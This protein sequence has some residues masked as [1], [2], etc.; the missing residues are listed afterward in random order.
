MTRRRELPAI[1][2]GDLVSALHGAH[3]R[4]GGWENAF[5]KV[6]DP[7]R[8]EGQSHG[9]YCVVYEDKRF[10]PAMEEWL[11]RAALRPR[12]K[13]LEGN[14]SGKKDTTRKA[15]DAPKHKKPKL[16]LKKKTKAAAKEP[17]PEDCDKTVAVDIEDIPKKLSP[18]ND[19]E[20]E[21]KAKEESDLPELEFMSKEEVALLP[22]YCKHMP[23]SLLEARPKSLQAT[24]QFIARGRGGWA[25]LQKLAEEGTA[26]IAE[27][28]HPKAPLFSLLAEKH[29]LRDP[30]S[31]RLHKGTPL[32]CKLYCLTT[33][34]GNFVVETIVHEGQSCPVYT[35]MLR[36]T[37]SSCEFY[38]VSFSH[39]SVL[40]IDMCVCGSIA[41]SLFA[42]AI[43]QATRMGVGLCWGLSHLSHVAK[44]VRY[45][46]IPSYVGIGRNLKSWRFPS[47]LFAR[48]TTSPGCALIVNS[49]SVSFCLRLS[50][51]TRTRQT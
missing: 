21:A 12:G 13:A 16:S 26:D 4:F 45:W 23:R 24:S 17:G 37:S 49:L 39:A 32:E 34:K 10:F 6:V 31:G 35:A 20:E 42:S 38:E 11:P 51:I 28:L 27:V 43:L 19:E 18:G 7:T 48:N 8:E 14:A 36:P 25:D 15:A 29:F 2:A 46:C 44:P 9:K 30:P 22:S 41:K 1:N 47:I 33:S 40:G 3:E 5:V 50:A